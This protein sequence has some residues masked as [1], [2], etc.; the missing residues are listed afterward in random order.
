MSRTSWL[1]S[2][3]G[4]LTGIGTA[5]YAERSGQPNIASDDL[6][7]SLL[8]DAAVKVAGHRFTP[9]FLFGEWRDVVD[10][11]QL[12]TWEAYRDVA[13]LG[14]KTR[15]GGRQRELLWSI[16]E[17]VRQGLAARKAVTWPDVFGRL[18]DGLARCGRSIAAL[19]PAFL[20]GTG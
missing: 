2:G 11:W 16:F 4:R 7:R 17:Q 20:G 12:P 18:A 1:A 6:V 5:L 8:R 13:R 9:Q 15:I 19:R 3:W 14:R 10:A